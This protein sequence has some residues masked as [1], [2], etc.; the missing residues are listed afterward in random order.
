MLK[1]EINQK[2]AWDA[3]EDNQNRLNFPNVKLVDIIHLA[4]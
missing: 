2:Y 1:S 4:I 3:K